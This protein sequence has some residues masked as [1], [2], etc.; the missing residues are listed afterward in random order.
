VT[1]SDQTKG[2][3]LFDLDQTLI[4]WDTQLLFC[5]FVLKR[6]PLRRLYLLTLLPLLPFYKLLGSDGLKRV[7]LN[8]L[9][10]LSQE[11]LDELAEAFVDQHFPETFY[12][13][14]LD[15]LAEQKQHGRTTVLSSASP[16]I[17]VKPIAEKLGF[18]HYFGTQVE[19][20]PRIPLFPDL[21]GGNNKGSNKLRKMQHI[22]PDGFNTKN[23]IL[24]N[25]FGFSDSHADLPMLHICEQA[26]MVHPT[27]R[28]HQEGQKKGWELRTPERPT[29]GK[30]QFALA[31]LKQAC[32]ICK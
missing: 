7:F 29:T 32:G 11:D 30:R 25:S 24:P 14:M 12:E 18:D 28:L 20:T 16:E 26:V 5:N 19:M 22:L 17:W 3:A 15:V 8:Y 6:M 9:W 13:E 10:G 23:D 2:Y 1:H 21:P 31:C 4:P 27:E